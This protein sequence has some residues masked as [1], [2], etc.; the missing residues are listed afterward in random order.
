M[1][2]IA[3]IKR[4]FLF[5]LLFIAF[6]FGLTDFTG[7]VYLPDAYAKEAVVAV[8]NNEIITQKDL[9]D[10]F[11]FMR[12]QYSKD[13]SGKELESKLQQVKMDL[14]DRLIE[15]RLILQE[16]KKEKVII[17]QNR[18][19]AKIA[20]IKKRYSSDNALELD[21]AK[22]GLVPAD[23]ENKI[24]EQFLMFAIVDAKVRSKIVI[25]PDDITSFYEQHKREFLKPETRE[26]DVFSLDDDNL[27]KTL[28]YNLRLGKKP[29]D[30]AR[31]YPFRASKMNASLGDEL[32]KEIQG[33]VFKLGISEVSNP[34]KIDNQYYIFRLNNIIGS[35]QLSLPQA[36]S[37]IHS[38]L[39]EMKMQEGLTR[40]LD[41]IKKRSYIKITGS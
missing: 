14:L 13:Y 36:Q 25:G 5:F 8:V 41:E 2:R 10:F 40:W 26:L 24:R 27:A 12:M 1:Q 15:D 28:A 35:Q 30:L 6:S 21:L 4:H 33:V 34:I 23:L 17:D 18:V 11:N 32:R 22:Q 3:K 38:F 16:A 31:L 7:K 19:K 29:E 9:N 20:D 37:R 39:Y